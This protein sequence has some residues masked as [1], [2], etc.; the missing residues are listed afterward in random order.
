MDL[1][2]LTKLLNLCK[3]IEPLPVIIFPFYLNFS[4]FHK[5][6]HDNDKKQ[7]RMN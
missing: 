6:F 4:M 3:N 5:I 2:F 1:H 7:K